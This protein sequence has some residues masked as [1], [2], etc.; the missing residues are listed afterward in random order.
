[1]IE[2]LHSYMNDLQLQ[3]NQLE[4]VRYKCRNDTRK[5]KDANVVDS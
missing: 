3:L 5:Q 4:K 2:E 1:M